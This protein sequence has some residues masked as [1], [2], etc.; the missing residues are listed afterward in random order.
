M[1]EYKAKLIR[2]LEGISRAISWHKIQELNNNINEYY[3]KFR[4]EHSFLADRFCIVYYFL[5]LD[6]SKMKL[7][8]NIVSY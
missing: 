5:N 6:Y 2:Y 4:N 8:K 3:V 1:T 7:V